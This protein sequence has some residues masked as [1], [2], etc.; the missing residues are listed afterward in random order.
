MFDCIYFLALVDY[1]KVSGIYNL[2]FNN[3]VLIKKGGSIFVQISK[4]CLRQGPS[5]LAKGHF[6]AW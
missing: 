1:H 2:V 5:Q 4:L 3:G 6:V